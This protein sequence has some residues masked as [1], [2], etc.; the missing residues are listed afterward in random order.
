MQYYDM[1]RY[2]LVPIGAGES[3]PDVGFYFCVSNECYDATFWFCEAVVF[4]VLA[5]LL[6]Y[7]VYSFYKLVLEALLFFLEEVS[8]LL[9]DLVVP[10]VQSIARWIHE[11]TKVVRDVPENIQSPNEEPEIHDE[12]TKVVVLDAEDLFEAA[13]SGNVR[14]IQKA[15]DY[16]G[17]NWEE[18]T[19]VQL[20]R[21]KEVALHAA[22]EKGHATVVQ[23]LL[24]KAHADPNARD[25]T[26][27]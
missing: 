13:K 17:N 2:I 23:L 12:R 11:R 9:Y 25:Y 5:A 4:T 15:L 26:C 22:A 3:H 16:G 1:V 6:V 19:S 14:V 21:R 18:L 8:S 27:T 7:S 20:G 24:E 10:P